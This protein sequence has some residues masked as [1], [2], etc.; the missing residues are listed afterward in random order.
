MAHYAT[1][2]WDCEIQ[3]SYGW[4]ECVGH[5]DRSCYDLAVHAKATNTSM[6]AAQRLDAPKVIDVITVE[7]DKKVI[8]KTF[9]GEQ[10][11]V[12]AA[13]A[14]LAEDDEAVSAFEATLSS[15]GQAEVEGGFVVTKDMVKFVRSSKEVQEEKFLP[16]VIEPSFGMGR[17]LYALLEH[18]FSQPDPS[19]EQRVVMRFNPAV[20][21]TKCHVYPLQSNAAFGPI[22]KRIADL[23]TAAGITN[24]VCGGGETNR[25]AIKQTNKLTN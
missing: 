10:K 6:T 8:G 12:I 17:I 18:S 16:S 15:V 5:A 24:K 11:K 14:A 3:T 4:I 2:C 13:L 19:D 25:Q 7:P 9:K 22:V 23:L 21:P 20:A 1:D